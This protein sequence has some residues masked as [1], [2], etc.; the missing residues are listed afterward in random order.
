MI[1]RSRHIFYLDCNFD[2]ISSFWPNVIIKIKYHIFDK[3]FFTKRHQ[4]EDPRPAPHRGGTPIP[5]LPDGSKERSVRLHCEV[6]QLRG[7]DKHIPMLYFSSLW[8]LKYDNLVWQLTRWARRKATTMRRPGQKAKTR[9]WKETIFNH[10][11]I[12]FDHYQTYTKSYRIKF[13]PTPKMRNFS[14]NTYPPV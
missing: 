12:Y 5:A 9:T 7:E 3:I 1:P 14:W 13:G 2:M 11:E 4:G 6:P 8:M 10:W